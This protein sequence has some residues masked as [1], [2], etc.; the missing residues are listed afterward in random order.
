MTQENPNYGLGD[1]LELKKTH[2]CGGKTWKV[3]RTGVD[4]KLECLTCG[5]VVMIPR[6]ELRKKVK[7]LLEKGAPE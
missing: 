7:K 6:L 1:I 4:Y 2:P 5:R 3:V